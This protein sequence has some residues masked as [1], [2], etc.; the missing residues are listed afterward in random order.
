[1]IEIGTRLS[2]DEVKQRLRRLFASVKDASG[3]HP[4]LAGEVREFEVKLTRTQWTANSALRPELTAAITPTESGGTRLN[5]SFG[6][7]DRSRLFIRGW[8][9]FLGIWLM[10]SVVVAASSES[11]VLW[12]LPCAAAA[13]LAAGTLFL[14][15]AGAFYRKDKEWLL[16]SVS[17]EVEGTVTRDD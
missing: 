10:I 6:L 13:L 7:A 16:R 11:S 3:V 5:G 12:F 17:Q 4:G 1:V 2:P 9:G 14:R 15:F 8:F